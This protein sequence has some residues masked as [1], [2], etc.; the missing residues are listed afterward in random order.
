MWRSHGYRPL[1]DGSPPQ[2]KEGWR[3]CPTVDSREGQSSCR[4]AKTKHNQL[5]TTLPHT[6]LLAWGEAGRGE[7]GL[8]IAGVCGVVPCLVRAVVPTLQG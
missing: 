4:V 6:R 1:A 8:V 7:Y 3:G 2:S 5:F